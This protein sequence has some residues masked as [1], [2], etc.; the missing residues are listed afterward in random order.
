MLMAREHWFDLRGYGELDL[1]STRRLDA[2][3]CYSAQHDGVSEELL[4][5]PMRVYHV[6]DIAAPE[7]MSDTPKDVPSF[8][9]AD[10]LWLVVQMRS[11]G[12]PILFNLDDWGLVDDSLP[13]SSFCEPLATSDAGR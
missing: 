8:S 10:L 9:S 11:L 5:E 2:L 3:L 7:G 6:G 4:R 13:E 12:S 1:L